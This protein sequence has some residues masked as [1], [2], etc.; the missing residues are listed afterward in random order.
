M[1]RPRLL[2]VLAAAVFLDAMLF[3]ALAPLLPHFAERLDLTKRGAGL[4]VAALGAGLLAGALPA[5]L[6]TTRA[7]SRRALVAGLVLLACS[8]IGFALA[9]TAWQ[10]AVARFAQGV[11]GAATW[12]AALSWIA[13][14]AP[15]E[16]RGGLI[17]GVFGAAV[18]GAIVGPL[19]GAAAAAVGIRE[20][21]V[22]VAVAAVALAVLVLRHE[23]PEAE[24]ATLRS[25]SRAFRDPGFAG[26]LWLSMLPALLFGVLQLLAP[27][28]LAHG[29]FGATGIGLTFFAAGLVEV[30]INPLVGRFSDRVGRRRPLRLALALSAVAAAALAVVTSNAAL[31]VLVAVAGI[32][33]GGLN[34][35]GLALIADRA[36]AVQVAQGLAFGAMALT[37]GAGN[38]LGPGVA[39]ALAEASGGDA[40]PYLAVCALCVATLLASYAAPAVHGA[41]RRAA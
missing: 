33:F 4:L 17:G 16:R 3:G 15:A 14:A 28:A 38:L 27:L 36:E 7:G 10:L 41:S 34:T 13:A 37:W 11:S 19:F 29:G 26:A 30:A 40:V 31:V 22:A 35:P 1:G 12:V 24:P 8:S 5:A 21:F 2:A 18:F 32:G 25:L 6:A 20:A 39:G 23:A 9:A